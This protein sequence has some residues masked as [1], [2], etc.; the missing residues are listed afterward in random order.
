MDDMEVE[1]LR[2]VES[3]SGKRA[4][5]GG[6]ERTTMVA[7]AAERTGAFPVKT[8][9]AKTRSFPRS[10]AGIWVAPFV[11]LSTVVVVVVVVA[12]SSN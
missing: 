3:V 6:C 8:R 12:V 11:L 5:A 7:A 10:R 9:C 2:R 1:G 4:S